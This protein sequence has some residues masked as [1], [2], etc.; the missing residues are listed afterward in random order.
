MQKL[1]EMT[2]SLEKLTG[3]EEEEESGS[4]IHGSENCLRDYW[5]L[6]L[7]S[8]KV[9]RLLNTRSAFWRSRYL[10]QLVCGNEWRC[11]GGVEVCGRCMGRG[12]LCGRCGCVWEV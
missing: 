8:S 1:V 7:C 12:E 4:S 5:S 6:E 2:G 9:R 11:V 3:V 10:L